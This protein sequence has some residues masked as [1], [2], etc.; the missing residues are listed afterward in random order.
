VKRSAH[1]TVA[2]LSQSALYVVFESLL[3]FPREADQADDDWDTDADFV[4]D[5]SEE[6]QRWGAKSV[7]GSVESSK[8]AV[9]LSAVREST[10]SSHN[11]L[12]QEQY[13]A[14]PT[15]AHGYGG[16]YGVQ[17]DRVD[18]SAL[19]TS[20][21]SKPAPKPTTAAKPEVASKADI[22]SRFENM[23]KS[24]V[25]DAALAME[26]KRK[27]RAAKEKA[28][29][30][31]KLKEQKLR[32]AEDKRRSDEAAAA[33][34][35]EAEEREARM[36]EQRAAKLA[37]QARQA[38]EER[39]R[40]EEEKKMQHEKEA[41]EAAPA[42]EYVSAEAYPAEE[43]PAEE[44]PAEEY[45]AEE[46]PAEE[47]PAEEYPAE[48]YPAE[49][50]PAEEYPAEEY[51]A[52]EYHAEDYPSEAAY[53]EQA[54]AGQYGQQ[55]YAS[56]ETVEAEAY[57]FTVRALYEYEAS[58]DDE[59]SFAVGDLICNCSV[60]DDG[61]WQGQCNESYGMFPANFVEAVEE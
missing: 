42:E 38:E 5:I 55:H 1:R 13:N 29:K 24:T 40:Q 28:E 57:G 48:E 49:E 14:K 20:H 8:Q 61:W 12:T 58:G 41:E 7:A 36:A 50:N 16:K 54:C 15:F 46:Y 27:E 30:E 31:Q 11:K 60:I 33:K 25:D 26:A 22:R 2:K 43:Y 44:Y 19:P 32:E 9:D 45:P 17:T 52:E 23:S 21:V 18:K 53:D 3:R 59:I 6:Q 34:A 35:K 4:N 10:V 56:A 39:H 47:Y 37:E 51:P